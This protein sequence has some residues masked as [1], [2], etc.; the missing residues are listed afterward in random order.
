MKKLMIAALAISGLAAAASAQVNFDRGFDLKEVVSAAVSADPAVPAVPGSKIGSYS[1]DCVRFT[2]GP[3]DS[4]ALSPKVYLRS[5]ESETVCHTVMVPGPNNTQ[6]PQQQCYERPGMTWYE[7]GQIKMADRKLLPWEKESFDMCL[8]G[9]WLNLYANS[10][11][12][13]YTAQR[14]GHSGYTLF[15]LTAH[16]KQPMRADE[17][18]VNYAEFAFRDGKFVFRASDKWARE[19]AG[20]KTAIKVELYKDNALFD[21]FKGEK[22]FLF[23]AADSYEM[24]FAEGDLAKPEADPADGLRGAKKYYLKW[25]FKRVG[26]VSKDNFVKKDKTPVITK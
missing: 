9:P 1:R 23:D 13:R 17:N 22:E 24:A 21:S 8:Q 26:A 25:G 7:Y 14:E 16:E 18:G 15:T 20:E 10:T 12:Y 4:G 11:G 3:E 6:V 2:F 19:Y 5:I